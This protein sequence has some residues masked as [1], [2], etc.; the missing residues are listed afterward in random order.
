MPGSS[1]DPVTRIDAPPPLE[2]IAGVTERIV[3]AGFV[4]SGWDGAGW[5]G[6]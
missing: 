4:N 5:T 3:G 1:P 2:P 6:W